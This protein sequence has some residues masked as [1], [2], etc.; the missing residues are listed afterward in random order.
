MHYYLSIS[1]TRVALPILA[2]VVVQIVLVV[3]YHDNVS[4]LAFVRL[5]AGVFTLVAVVAY[6]MFGDVFCFLKTSR[7]DHSSSRE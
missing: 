5:I 7:I 1:R 6:G 3:A 4:Q 2:G